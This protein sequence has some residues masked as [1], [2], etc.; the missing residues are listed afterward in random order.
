MIVEEDAPHSHLHEHADGTLHN[1]Y[2]SHP[3]GLAPHHHGASD[4]R[5]HP[6]HLVADPPRHAADLAQHAHAHQP[7]SRVILQT[8]QATYRYARAT[9]PAFE[10]VDFAAQTGCL[11]AILGNN[12]AGKSTLL[13]L[14]GGLM[15]PTEGSVRIEGR[16]LHEMGHR[17]VAQH[18]AAVTQQQHIPHLSVYDEVLLGR[19]PH[20]AWSV[21]DYDREVVVRVIE[22]LRLA[23]FADRYVD[24]LSGGERQKV[25]IARALAQEPEVLL[26]DEPTSALDPKNQIEVLQAVREVTRSSSLAT[27]LVL[28]DIN[29]ALRFCDRFLL[30]RDGQVV[31]SGGLEAVTNKTLEATYDHP[32]QIHHVAGNAV[33]V[34]A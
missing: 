9:R 34:P 8:E 3:Q 27:I 33:V 1:H 30:L 11:H 22:R 15:R 32:L 17:E 7:T 21:S 19:R 29:L 5:Q 18:I 24:Q 2:H 28:H 16:P 31:A 12:G 13:A 14:L 10:R 6:P 4:V 25:F 26:L 23:E 20:I